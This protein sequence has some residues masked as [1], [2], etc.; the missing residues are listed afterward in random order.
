MTVSR[1][2]GTGSPVARRRARRLGLVLGSPVLV[3]SLAAAATPA[4]AVPQ[5]PAAPQSA[6]VLCDPAASQCLTALIGGSAD[7]FTVG[8]FGGLAKATLFGLVND[9]RGNPDCPNL[10]ERGRDWVLVGFQT[11][12]QGASWT[13][14][15]TLSGAAPATQEAAAAALESSFVCFEAPY[16]FFNRPGFPIAKGPEGKPPFSAVLASCATVD[17]LFP[18][19]SR[20]RVQP[21]PCVQSREVVASGNGFV[22]QSVVRIPRDTAFTRLRP[23]TGSDPASIS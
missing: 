12:Q 22:V 7:A 11:L 20:G 18:T 16:R 23:G 1:V 17:S 4:G 10:D 21:L 8:A 9:K 3:A 2:G 13:K 6:K 5:R 15:V 14:V 19:E